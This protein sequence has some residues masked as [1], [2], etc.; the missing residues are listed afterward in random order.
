MSLP[1]A[2]RT[3]LAESAFAPATVDAYKRAASEFLE[4]GRG[5]GFSPESFDELDDLL[6]DYF[7]ELYSS[8]E[9]V[10]KGVNTYYG[11]TM[12]LPRA[13]GKM[14]AALLSLRGWRRIQPSTPRPPLTWNLTTVMAIRMVWMGRPEAAIATLLAF[15][16]YLRISEFCG[17]RVADVSSPADHRL[18]GSSRVLCRLRNTKTGRNQWVEVRR[19]EVIALLTLAKAGKSPEASLFG[20]STVSYSQLFNRV[21]SSLG[22]D[23]YTPHSLRHGG[24]THDHL[25][26]A[27]IES[28]LER[29][30]WA[31]A[32]S[33][34]RYIQS[35]RALLLA[36]QVPSSVAE[37]GAV[38]KESLLA[39]FLSALSQSRRRVRV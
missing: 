19:P 33:A 5:H 22:L 21:V 36:V 7:H 26:G 4:W 12:C 23:A 37:A 13:K 32:K 34:R 31:S 35:G 11:I 15:D 38:F 8:G 2:A 25:Q 29:G 20:L 1:G 18:D 27:T 6:V 24:A 9:G 3:H 14:N 39:A 16:C 28:I 30:R 10:Q 17:L